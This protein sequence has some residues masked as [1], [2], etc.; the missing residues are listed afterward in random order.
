M[1]CGSSP[2]PASAFRARQPEDG[3]GRKRLDF[4]A[5]PGSP[6]RA[7]GCSPGLTVTRDA[8]SASSSSRE[9]IR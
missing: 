1:P 6:T 9:T 3:G 2:L 4:A 5:W 8:A 7:A